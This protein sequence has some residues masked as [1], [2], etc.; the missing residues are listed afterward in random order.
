MTVAAIPYH[1]DANPLDMVLALLAAIK[2]TLAEPP[3]RG[4]VWTLDQLAATLGYGRKPARYI[5]DAAAY[6]LGELEAIVTDGSEAMLPQEGNHH[7][8]RN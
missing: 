5:F 1:P 6:H 3:L 2:A 8:P 4:D 7:V